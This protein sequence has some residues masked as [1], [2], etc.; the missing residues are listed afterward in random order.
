MGT[1]TK[2]QWCHHTFNPWLGCDKCSEGCKNCYAEV[3]TP[4]RVARSKGLELWGAQAQ[5]R[6]ASEEMWKQPL[7]WDRDAEKAGIRHR[8]FC[9][10]LA[11]VFEDYRGPDADAVRAARF[12]LITLIAQT[13]HLNWLLLTKRPENVA[14]LWP[15][16]LPGIQH[17]DNIWIGCTVENQ[18]RA[19]QRLPEL[20]KIPA[21]IRFVSYEPAL[22]AVDFSRW[23][24]PV[25][26]SWD[27][28]YKTPEDALAAGSAV[29]RH[30]QALVHA[31]ARFIDWVIVGGE[32]GPGARR[33]DIGWA[34]S[35]VK[36]CQEGGVACFFKQAGSKPFIDD[37][38]LSL[39]DRKGGDLDELPPDLRVREFPDA[40]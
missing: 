40:A 26:S 7:K 11:D 28:K 4:V 21:V 15:V 31:D 36:Q 1:D 16:T 14:K 17:Y 13:P 22:E 25:H 18:A 19:T 10:S 35:V 6:I 29:G 24:W 34:R 38:P 37:K 27:S 33:F 9:A 32:S 20:L 23:M 30:R 12:R 2:V 5:R 39:R 8:V 3:S